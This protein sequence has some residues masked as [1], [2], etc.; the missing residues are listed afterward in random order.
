MVRGWT[1]EASKGSENGLL[2]LVRAEDGPSSLRRGHDGVMPIIDKLGKLS[3][4]DLASHV[5]SQG[6]PEQV[7]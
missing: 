1:I 5:S 2:R 3:I 4:T 7:S 6:F